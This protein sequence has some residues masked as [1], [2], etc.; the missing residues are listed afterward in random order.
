[1][2]HRLALVRP[3]PIALLFALTLSM[4][5]YATESPAKPIQPNCT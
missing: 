4:S 3:L 5:S 1:M 2:R